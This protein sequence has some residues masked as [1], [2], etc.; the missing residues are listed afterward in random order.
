MRWCAFIA[1]INVCVDRTAKLALVAK[2]LQKRWI[3]ATNNMQVGDMVKSS[4]DMNITSSE[5][6]HV[7]VFITTV[8]CIT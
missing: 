6:K 2:G 3:I 8:A 7:L 5:F 4:T 1:I